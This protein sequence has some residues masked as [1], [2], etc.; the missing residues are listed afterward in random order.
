MIQ[1]KNLS[2]IPGLQ[3]KTGLGSNVPTRLAQR[4]R[5]QRIHDKFYRMLVQIRQENEQSNNMIDFVCFSQFLIFFMNK[6]H[7]GCAPGQFHPGQLRKDTL[8]SLKYGPKDRSILH[9]LVE[10]NKLVLFRDLMNLN[11]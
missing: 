5:S 7:E 6:G 10:D 8:Q 2:L 9:Q 1:K 3:S 11:S 4:E